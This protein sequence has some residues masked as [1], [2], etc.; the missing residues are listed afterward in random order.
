ME[1]IFRAAAMYFILLLIFRLSGKRT[2]SEADTFDFMMLLIISETT[3]QAMV[4]D[5]K[6]FTTAALLIM[7]LVFLT[8][9]LSYIKQWSPKMSSVLDDEPFV[10]LSH[11][12][13]LK[14]RCDKLRVDEA[15]IM[16]TARTNFGLE[17]ME[18]IKF[19]VVERNGSISIIPVEN[20][21]LKALDQAS[22][23]SPPTHSS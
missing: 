14:D 19:A 15:D 4:R 20:P 7:T 12:Q 1:I 17:R 2:M 8:I 23:T 13:P 6:S 3:Q 22:S 11:G 21:R 16:E 5:D 9:V 10:V 18:Q